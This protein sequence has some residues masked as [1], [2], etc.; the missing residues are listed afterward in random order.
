MKEFD[1]VE[2]VS[3]KYGEPCISIGWYE[4]AK[5]KKFQRTTLQIPK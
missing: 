2:F 5:F 4:P 3:A 1:V